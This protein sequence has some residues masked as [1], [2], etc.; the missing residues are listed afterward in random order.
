MNA[1]PDNEIVSSSGIG[2][3]SPTSEWQEVYTNALL[4]MI[5][6]IVLNQQKMFSIVHSV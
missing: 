5:A 6:M 4:A 3:Q 2:G 1:W